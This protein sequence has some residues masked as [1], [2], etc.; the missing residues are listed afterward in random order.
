ME[1]PKAGAAG[2]D[3]PRRYHQEIRCKEF[4]LPTSAAAANSLTDGPPAF[5][6]NYLWHF[7][8]GGFRHRMMTE[9]F[10]HQGSEYPQLWSWLTLYAGHWLNEAVQAQKFSYGSADG[11]ADLLIFDWIG[12]LVFLNDDVSEFF[13]DTLHFRDW[14]FQTSYNPVTNSLYNTGQLMGSN[15]PVGA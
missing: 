5:I 2:P 8:G 12:K 4:S 9:Y 1:W 13:A 15:R 3:R 7:I 11:L 6:P 10:T 14:S